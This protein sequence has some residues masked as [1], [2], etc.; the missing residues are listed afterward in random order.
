MVPP[1][2]MVLERSFGLIDSK[3]LMLAAELGIADQ[4]EQGPKTA[5]E[6]ARIVGA[7][8]D[9]LDRMLAYMV[10]AG[11]LGRS[12]DGRYR[13]NAASN[14]L[15]RNHPQSVRDWILFSGADWV[16]DV[17][18]QLGHSIRTGESG[19]VKAHKVPFFEYVSQA[20]AAGSVFTK[21]LA[22]YSSVQGPFVAG[23]YDFSAARRVCDV[24][25]GSG[26]LPAQV[27]KL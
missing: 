5:E 20:N 8:P 1:E 16:W 25:G 19:T 14:R 21:A 26:G 15:R 13:N 6:L 24:G 11:F 2:I 23:K 22:F 17:W 9:A 4:L 27:L 3:A 7:N 12:G 10:S 18:N